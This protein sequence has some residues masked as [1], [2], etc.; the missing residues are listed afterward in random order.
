MLVEFVL[1]GHLNF[2][3]RMKSIAMCGCMHSDTLHMLFD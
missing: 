2:Y 3:I 1:L